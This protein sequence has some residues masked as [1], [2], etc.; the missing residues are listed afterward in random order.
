MCAVLSGRD[1]VS[2]PASPEQ[3]LLLRLAS[4][5]EAALGPGDA[6][7]L[8][9]L[10]REGLLA[11]APPSALEALE[12]RYS[13]WQARQ[14]QVLPLRRLAENLARKG[15]RPRG[16]ARLFRRGPGGAPEGDPQ[17]GE[18]WQGLAG[19]GMEVR[20]VHG[21]EDVSRRL[22]KLLAHL[23]VAAKECLDRLSG[24]EHELEAIRALEARRLRVESGGE[25][26]LTAA[27][28]K[29]LPEAGVLQDL[30][31]ALHLLSG[32]RRHKIEDYAH[33]REDPAALLA[34]VLE[35]PGGQPTQSEAIAAFEILAAALE[36]IPAFLQGTTPRAQN[37]FLIR[38]SRSHRSEPRR[39]F[40]WA[41]RERVQALRE[42]VEGTLLALPRDGW[43]L[44][45][46]LD[47][48]HTMPD[49]LDRDLAA[50]FGEA[51]DRLAWVHAKLSEAFGPPPRQ[52]SLGGNLLLG[53]LH[54]AASR[55][56]A[57]PAMAERCLENLLEV[58]VEAARLAPSGLQEPWG[59]AAFGFALASLTEGVASRLPPLQARLAGLDHHLGRGGSPAR[60]EVLLH[61]LLS[62]LRLEAQG[63]AP[64][65]EAYGGTFRRLRDWIRQDP[66]LERALNAA[67][68]H[69]EDRDRLAAM[70]TARAFFPRA[71][72]PGVRRVPAPGVGGSYEDTAH[73]AAPLLGEA[74]GSLMMG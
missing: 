14:Q 33:F 18:L 39:A 44:V 54:E 22:P 21:P 63:A 35:C 62:L 67:R 70:L 58:A 56:F 26:V 23:E 65:E 30:E 2:S 28:R 25:W 15:L 64:T 43:H 1:R 73:G 68:G 51:R 19:L 53:V 60:P 31:A 49:V 71:A 29:A 9:C 10:R 45:R 69:P 16:L 57:S 46:A 20:G 40:L 50:V 59:R 24:I 27:G 55:G 7:A 34:F 3:S 37:A 11:P 32:P 66:D 8:E 6:E 4:D 52:S 38:L 74:F 12:A 48:L 47:L 17:A 41:S 13:Q 42:G 61:A 5:G 72:A 36:R